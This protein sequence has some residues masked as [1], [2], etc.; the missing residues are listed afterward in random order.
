MK[1][2]PDSVV[3]EVWTQ[4]CESTPTQ[5]RALAQR[6]QQQQP[7]ITV[8]LLAAEEEWLDEPDR[9]ML[10]TLGTFIWLVMSRGDVPLRTVQEAELDQAEEANIRALEAMDQESEHDQAEAIQRLVATYNQMPLL[11][12]VLDVL[13]AG[14]ED[15]PQLAP[16]SVGMAL[17]HL[18]TVIDCLD[19]QGQ[20]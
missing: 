15:A 11:G 2:I 4:L 19:Q 14:H 17:L 16:D 7:G 1:T 8:Y 10:L 9:G 13:M 18:K 20:A 12:A 6:M 3:Q 5:V